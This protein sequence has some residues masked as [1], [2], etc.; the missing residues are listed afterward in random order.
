MNKYNP[1]NIPELSDNRPEYSLVTPNDIDNNSNKIEQPIMNEIETPNINKNIVLSEDT[2]KKIYKNAKLS[3]IKNYLPFINK[4]FIE[5]EI[6]TLNRV[7]M[8]LAQVGHESAELLYVKELASGKA[9]EGRKDLGN[10]KAGDGVKFKGR[11]LIQITG[12]SNYSELSKDFGVDLLN[13][14]ELLETP[15]L[16]VRSAFWF[17]SKNNLNKYCDANDFIKLTK[18]INGGTNGLDDRQRLLELAKQN[19]IIQ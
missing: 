2:L 6:D 15:E 18:R 8:F 14:P 5:Y 19:I 13:K 16:A 10:I 12:R 3:N 11:G 4:Y 9:Y 17:W 1:L 7:Q